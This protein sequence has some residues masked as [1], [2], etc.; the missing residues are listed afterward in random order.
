MVKKII[1]GGQ[2]G[3]DRAALDFAI[4]FDIPHGGWLPRGR[5][6]E[7]GPLPE[8]YKLQETQDADYAFRTEKNVLN[9]DGTLIVSHG[10]LN[11]GSELTQKFAETHYRPCLHVDLT[12][13]GAF[14]AAQA[15]HGWI[16]ENDIEIMNVAGPRSSKDPNIYKAVYHLLETVYFLNI[17]DTYIPEMASG[18]PLHHQ[19]TGGS[20][21]QTLSAA[22]SLL[23]DRLSFG[24][25]SRIANYPLDRLGELDDT[26]GNYIL[27][28]FLLE[29]ENTALIESC[30][31]MAADSELTPLK[32]SRLI[33]QHLRENLQQKKNLL[34]VVK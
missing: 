28:I 29:G 31:R 7:D 33:I 5:K 4:K 32:A 26:L 23:C 12:S 16:S 13:Q 30:R 2:T 8:K 18:R 14:Q 22:V 17:T 15:V 1:S 27:K 10:S 3:A 9:S 6:A 24:D 11:G 20:S 34:K 19:D 25:K 21:P